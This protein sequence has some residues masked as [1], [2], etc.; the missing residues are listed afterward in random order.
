MRPAAH[1]TIGNELR[2][3]RRAAGLTQVGLASRLG[4]RQSHIS[5]YETGKRRIYADVYRRWLDA[6]RP[7]PGS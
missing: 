1:V 4:L 5:E 7:S 2:A 6:C 3:A